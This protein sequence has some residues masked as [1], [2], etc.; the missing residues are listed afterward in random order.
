VTDYNAT[1]YATQYTKQYA[2]QYTEIV[3]KKDSTTISTSINSKSEYDYPRSILFYVSGPYTG[4]SCSTIGIPFVHEVMVWVRTVRNIVRARRVAI[5]IWKLGGT[6]ICPHLNT[7]LFNEEKVNYHDYLDGDINIMLRCDVLVLME[8]WEES[9]GT[10]Y[11][12]GQAN[13]H[14]MTIILEDEVGKYIEFE[15]GKREGRG[16]GKGSKNKKFVSRVY[17]DIIIKSKKV[18]GE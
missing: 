2:T 18:E 10:A 8:K 3:S 15:K 13:I 16:K 4:R 6:A 11:E 12:V 9:F 1:K 7:A 14:G 5:K 17:R